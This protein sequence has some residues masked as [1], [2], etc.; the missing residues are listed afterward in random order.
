MRRLTNHS[1]TP[2]SISD[3][4]SLPSESLLVVVETG[5]VDSVITHR[6]AKHGI[7]KQ[8]RSFVHSARG[9]YCIDLLQ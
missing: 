4:L 8:P 6:A 7:A 2:F 5:H 9:Y 1:R 3:T